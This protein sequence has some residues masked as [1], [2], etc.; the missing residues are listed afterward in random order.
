MAQEYTEGVWEVRA[1]LK[2]DRSNAEIPLRSFDACPVN[3]SI[4]VLIDIMTKAT[5]EEVDNG[6]LPLERMRL[7]DRTFDS[8]YEL[9]IIFQRGWLIERGDLCS[10]ETVVQVLNFTGW[11]HIRDYG[12]VPMR[13]GAN[14]DSLRRR[15]ITGSQV[16]MNWQRCHPT[17]DERRVSTTLHT[18][19]FQTSN[20]PTVIEL[21]NGMFTFRNEYLELCRA[22]MEH[23]ELCLQW[24]KLLKPGSYMHLAREM[25]H[26]LESQHRLWTEWSHL[27]TMPEFP[28]AQPRVGRYTHCCM[29]VVV[30]GLKKRIRCCAEPVMKVCD[31]QR[32]VHTDKPYMN[33]SKT[34]FAFCRSH[35]PRLAQVNEREFMSIH[36]DGVV[37]PPMF[38]VQGLSDSTDI[39]ILLTPPCM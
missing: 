37:A 15:E 29:P 14:A 21:D 2:S 18:V 4:D 13:R 19:R 11:P 28:L 20:L 26:M 17:E 7:L 6:A 5:L 30:E 16:A 38:R 39:R 33:P 36:Y 22:R 23:N 3:K 34:R 1:G 35:M 31:R 9:G 8:W 24:R 32:D 25:S 27:A 12:R 10:S